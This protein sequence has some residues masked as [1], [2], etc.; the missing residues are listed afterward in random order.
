MVAED[1]SFRQ[2]GRRLLHFLPSFPLSFLASFPSLR[3]D[4]AMSDP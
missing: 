4:C 3:G 1:L 2:V